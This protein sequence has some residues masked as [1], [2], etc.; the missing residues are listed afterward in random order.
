VEK[1]SELIEKE[2]PTP[3][4]QVGGASTGHKFALGPKALACLLVCNGLAAVAIALAAFSAVRRQDTVFDRLQDMSNRFDLNVSYLASKIKAGRRSYS[5]PA[6]DGAHQ[7]EQ[8]RRYT[9]LG[10]GHLRDHQYA[11]AIEAFTQALKHNPRPQDEAYLRFQLGECFFALG[12]YEAAVSQYQAASSNSFDKTHATIAQYQM[13]E[14]LFEMGD[15]AA[16]RRAFAGVIARQAAL[17]A[18]ERD[19]LGQAYY[20]VADCYYEQAYR[21]QRGGAEK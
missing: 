11:K 3:G 20:R 7:R 6:T 18:T 15:F 12:Q 1:A 14:S 16:A 17:K 21:S 9:E 19:L 8:Q 10:N 5:D 4:A 13:G 2:Q